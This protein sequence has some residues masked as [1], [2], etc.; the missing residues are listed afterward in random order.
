MSE[1]SLLI[2]GSGTRAGCG[3]TFFLNDQTAL[4]SDLF[5][6]PEKGCVLGLDG[7]WKETINETMT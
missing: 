2:F 4:I 6:L 1:I 5:L 3:R 7:K